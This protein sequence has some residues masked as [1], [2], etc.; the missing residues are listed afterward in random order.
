M[1]YKL[2][3][4][5]LPTQ[6]TAFHHLAAWVRGTPRA[7]PVEIF[8]TNYD[9]LAEQALED[10][11]VPY[12]DGFIGA[13]EAFFDPYSIE[14]EESKM[15]ARWARVWKLHGS[16]NWW[17]RLNGASH[18]ILRSTERLGQ[19]RLI[20]PS[21]LKYD[22]SRQMPYLA[23]MDRLKTFLRKPAAVLV[24]C[25]YSF[26]DRHVN[27]LIRQALDGNP[28]A[29]AFGLLFGELAC[30]QEAVRLSEITPNLSLMAKDQAIVGTRKAAWDA[31]AV[32]TPPPIA[33]KV[34]VIFP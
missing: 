24:I 17:S 19:S 1:K 34:L 33:I 16:I 4:V 30:Y 18:E 2:A 15:P 27:A 28:E 12:F 32:T 22:E 8:T 29:M 25:G 9:L 13:R 5:S 11:R 26:G 20:H 14:T 6:S 7:T 23:M 10:L 31:I 3:N 21:H